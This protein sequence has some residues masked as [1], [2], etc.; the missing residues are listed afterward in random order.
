MRNAS[1]AIPN[2]DRATMLP[3]IIIGIGN[4][5]RSD[6]GLGWAF[7]DAIKESGVID[8]PMIYR[9][10]LQVEDAELIS[11]YDS[12][13]FVD[14]TLTV[15]QR[16]FQIIQVMPEIERSF[17][18]HALEPSTIVGLCEEVYGVRP[19]THLLMIEGEQWELSNRLSHIGRL[20]LDEAVSA[21]TEAIIRIA[22]TYDS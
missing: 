12:V 10:Q 9:Y 7:L 22:A 17:T 3:Q 15:L 1:K 8:C 6:D 20:N 19:Q 14:A 21:F 16:G 18:T 11:H 5:G 4:S 2:P 13:L